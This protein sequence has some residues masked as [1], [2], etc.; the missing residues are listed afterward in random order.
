MLGRVA[1]G[2][3]LCSSLVIWG[4]RCLRRRARAKW[5]VLLGLGLD[6]EHVAS[7]RDLGF[8]EKFLGCV[9]GGVWM[10]F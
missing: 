3:R 8:A 4:L 2:W 1:W 7:S 9:G 6:G 10:L 5:D